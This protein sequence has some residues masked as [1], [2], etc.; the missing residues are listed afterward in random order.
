[1]SEEPRV[2]FVSPSDLSYLYDRCPRCYWL[3]LRGLKGPR[4]IMPSI[5]RDIDQKQKAAI[6]VEMVR[7]LGIPA[8]EFLPK[9]RVASTP[10]EYGGSLLAVRGETDKLA[11]LDDDTVAILDFKTSYP[12]P[13]NRVKFWRAMQAYCKAV[14][15]GETPR[16]VSRLALIVF[17]PLEYRARESNITEVYYKGQMARIDIELDR[18]KFEKLLGGV[19]KMLASDDMPASGS[20]DVCRHADEVVGMRM[21]SLLFKI[22]QD[23]ELGPDIAG[24][25]AARIQL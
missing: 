24:R 25:I 4:D 11:L 12:R 17:T 23:P 5:F 22:S 20:C 3:K 19:G 10:A 2:H 16:P 18:P 9:N 1:M 14:E 7:K 8:K 6:T 15:E 21:N 13:D